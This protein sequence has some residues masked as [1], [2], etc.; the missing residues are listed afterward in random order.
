[1]V[2]AKAMLDVVGTGIVG[3]GVLCAGLAIGIQ[4]SALPES[5]GLASS[6]SEFGVSRESHLSDAAIRQRATALSG[7]T[8]PDAQIPEIVGGRAPVISRIE[9]KQPVV[10]FTIDD[11]NYKDPS[12]IAAMQHHNLKATLFLAD[13]FI[14]HNHQ[15]FDGLRKT[16]SI[17]E[18]HT[19]RHDL[20]M[21]Q[22]N[23][24]YQHH[25]ICGM[26]DIVTRYYGR[27]PTL[28]RPPGG[29][30]NDD[31]QRIVAECGMRAIIMWTARVQNGKIEYQDGRTSLR[32]GDI[33]LLHF[34]P[35]FVSDI[36]AFVAAKNEAKLRVELL[37]NW[38]R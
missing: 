27:R 38:I 2:S 28:F 26:S 36:A 31:T 17:V 7:L 25:E 14:W 9:T 18:N 1:M 34:R 3:L 20:K 23:A 30:Y 33:V 24:T 32:P 35:E 19:D 29:R 5:I 13:L 16:G 6:R 15:F 22:H 4:L 21:V 12:V 11:G 10:F 8:K 37:E